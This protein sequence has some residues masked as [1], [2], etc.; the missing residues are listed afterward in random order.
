MMKSI[1]YNI[2]KLRKK[3]EDIEDKIEGVNK[4]TKIEGI[5]TRDTIEQ[6]VTVLIPDSKM[7][8]IDRMNTKGQ[9]GDSKNAYNKMKNKKSFQMYHKNMSKKELKDF[10]I[11]YIAKISAKVLLIS[12]LVFLVKN[13]FNF[14]I[15]VLEYV[16]MFF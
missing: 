14:F 10:L 7:K 4:I 8:M 5:K 16:R 3:I 6:Q 12:I 13:G 15:P 11:K 2:R 1:D 9:L